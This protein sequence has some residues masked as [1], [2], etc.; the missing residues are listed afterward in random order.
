MSGSKEDHIRLFLIRH[1]HSIPDSLSNMSDFDNDDAAHDARGRDETHV[2]NNLVF[3]DE[4][5]EEEEEKI[6]H[7]PKF[8]RL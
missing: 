2:E 7:L 6:H 8:A 4:E 3:E 1:S 5:E